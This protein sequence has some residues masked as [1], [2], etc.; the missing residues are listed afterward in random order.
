MCYR[1]GCDAVYAG[2]CECLHAYSRVLVLQVFEELYAIPREE[3]DAAAI[4][5][6]LVRVPSL[7]A[8]DIP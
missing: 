6:C 5:C 7:F 8:R 4:E 3:F 1:P 2:M